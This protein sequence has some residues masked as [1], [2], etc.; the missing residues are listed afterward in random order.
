[1]VNQTMQA[2]GM[3]NEERDDPTFKIPIQEG[4]TVPI[5][6]ASVEKEPKLELP[7]EIKK[8]ISTEKSESI[9][10]PRARPEGLKINRKSPIDKVLELDYLL[11]GK[12][13]RGSK[14]TQIISNLYEGK[15]DDQKA[16]KGFMDSAVGGDT[17]YDPT[18]EAWCAAFVAHILEQLGADPL[19]SK[20]R[21]DRLRANAYRNYGSAVDPK[22]IREGD[23]VVFDFDKDGTGD[24]VT[25]YAGDRITSQGEGNYINIVG[26]NHGRGEVSIRENHPLYIW[27]NV[28]ATRRITYN[29]ID[30][31]FTQEMAKQNPVFN[32]FLPEYAKLET[33]APATYSKGG[34]ETGD[35]TN[36][37]ESAIPTK[38]GMSY[39]ELILDNILGLDNEYESF[40][41][42]LGKAV[43]ED[44]I[45]FLKT[46]AVGV[47]EGAK[48]FITNP[49]ETT[50]QVVTDIK[51]SIQR[52]GTE[53]LNK[54]LKN[55]YN[56]DYT[57][58]TDEQVNSAK[59]AVFGDALR[60]LELIP[61]AKGVT[62]IAKAGSAAIP[63]G[64]KADVIGQ[65]K[66]LLSGDKEFL[67]GTPTPQSSTQS[68]SA[69]FTGQN[70]PTY[71]KRDVPFIEGKQPG[72]KIENP[73]DPEY[74]QNVVKDDLNKLR[75]L[76]YL[77]FRE[78]IVEFAETVTIPKKGLLGS[79]FL[80]QLKK[81][82]AT[83]ESSL[84][85]GVIDPDKRYTK[86]ELL[87]TLKRDTKDPFSVLRQP[88]GTFESRAD[89]KYPS[90]YE[91]YQRQYSVGFMGGI[92][93][94]Y[95]SI[96]IR[97]TIGTPGK[98]FKAKG[99][100][101]GFPD[102][103][104]AHVRGSILKTIPI[105][106][107]QAT[108]TGI[109]GFEEY[110]NIIGSEKNFL[111]FEE[112]QSDLLTGG[113]IKPTNKFDA[114]FQLAIDDYNEV[115]PVSYREAY[116]GIT[117]DIEQIVKE[118][119]N[120]A[121]GGFDIPSPSILGTYSFTKEK[122]FLDNAK[123]R[124]YV[125][126][127]ELDN[128][129]KSNGYYNA[130]NIDK[131]NADTEKFIEQSI[132]AKDIALLNDVDDYI[133]A[134]DNV[135]N[136]YDADYDEL[137][138]ETGTTFVD[139]TLMSF[140][141]NDGTALKSFLK[142]RNK[143]GPPKT[144]EQYKLEVNNFYNRIQK[145]LDR[146]KIDKEIDALEF[147]DIY[148]YY[149]NNKSSILD[150]S[151]IGLPPIRKEKQAIDEIIKVLIAKAA[152]SDAESIV[153]PPPARIAAARGK[154]YRKSKGDKFYRL[155]EDTFNK[156]LKELEDNFPVTIHR[157]VE[158]PYTDTFIQE[159]IMAEAG[160]VIDNKGTI[161]DISELV[162][163]YKV[164]EPRQFAQGGVAMNNQMEMAFMNQGGL[165][166][167]GMK[168]DPVSGNPIP[169]G[170]MAE[171]VRDDIP[172]QLSE[173]E[174]VV[175]ADVVRYYGVKHF[176]DIRNNAK[177]G[178]QSMEANG[179][180]GGEP[181]PV[182]GP[183][184]GM[185]QQMASDLSQDEMQEIQ[186]M[187]MNVGGFV[188]QPSDPYQQQQTMYQQPM[189]MG[190]NAGT[191]VPSI[192][193]AYAT[194]P[195]V[196]GGGF[197]FEPP[198]QAAPAIA[199]AAKKAAEEAEIK[200]GETRCKAIGKVY[201]KETKLCEDDPKALEQSS[202][203]DPTPTE[204]PDPTAWMDS[205]NYNDPKLL[206]EQITAAL[207]PQASNTSGFLGGL[208]NFLK[209]RIAPT[210]GLIDIVVKG[211]NAAQQAANIELLKA[212]NQ[213]TGNLETLL[214][215]YIVDNK[216]KPLKDLGLMNG[217]GYLKTLVTEKGK[218]PFGTGTTPAPKPTP[219]D[220]D[221]GSSGGGVSDTAVQIVDGQEVKP[222]KPVMRPRSRPTT[223]SSPKVTQTTPVDVAKEQESSVNVGGP[224]FRNKGGLMLKKKKTKGK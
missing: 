110:Y 220:D 128:Y 1:M 23:I 147:A 214:E 32:K 103:T 177:Q 210:G 161:I 178:L 122:N 43:N 126:F 168:Q 167:D 89:L 164:E 154:E 206:S 33:D 106:P 144:K 83:P 35:I 119:D 217:T 15:E 96:P 98:K 87:S 60:A 152:A 42:K 69:G 223:S 14:T 151:N 116:S 109:S 184:A 85:S 174:Y 34:L 54:R 2:F 92:E 4:S 200:A 95:F 3:L 115:S 176:E 101:H 222:T 172:A 189:A 82:D 209:S 192:T 50:K 31:K 61:A 41:E 38:K 25:F 163:K 165:K 143:K 203:K 142:Y 80:L 185:Q 74:M 166:D 136:Y 51:D 221:D 193:S 105:K 158:I 141:N 145:Q 201:N 21:Y 75:S 138:D 19:K 107:E 28:L 129:L 215:K 100:L 155:Y 27:D 36:Q 205:Y 52:L 5:Q 133:D 9:L 196:M 156:S 213:P 47:Y 127:S 71:L 66:A 112:G 49:V 40:G 59:E 118:L 26:G 211:T 149:K 171:E 170:S 56:I 30:F 202:D 173:G 111:L 212:N 131:T 46:A 117:K 104:I 53:D 130:T 134:D 63:S 97:S 207:S 44:E 10:R 188:D 219:K 16:I 148:L 175:P 91:S 55:M 65:T 62:T 208:G 22:D 17:G 84:Q 224:G 180:I 186:S 146:K 88:K 99:D 76:G 58:A 137:N 67:S 194:T 195:T 183:K 121:L 86:E 191:L 150:T 179:R 113:F 12:P 199:D 216:L 182:G 73:E 123:E 37:T 135:D 24:H 108:Y 160:D 159:D 93:Q 181:V 70:P 29:D 102:E 77:F 13:T 78:P 68:L 94:D 39:G 197:S 64:V 169:N 190:A 81:N 114:V 218:N 140:D 187:M 157:D 20:D 11:K 18:I 124:G 57:N 48:E 45:S 7:K 72:F 204:T 132:F 125:V 120:D 79:E 6:T 139:G 8:Q 198:Q 153:I 162:R 90:R